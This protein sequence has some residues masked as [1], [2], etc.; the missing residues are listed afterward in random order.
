MLKKLVNDKIESMKTYFNEKLDSLKLDLQ[1]TTVNHPVVKNVNSTPMFNPDRH[2]NV[3][4]FGCKEEE[5]TDSKRRFDLI[6]R[7]VTSNLR[8]IGIDA[9]PSIRDFF[10]RGKQTPGKNRPIILRASN[11]WEKRKILASYRSQKA[12][13]NLGFTVL[14]D[15]P[16]NPALKE[17]KVKARKL[18]ED[19]KKEAENK[20]TMVTKSFSARENG[21]ITFHLRNGKWQQE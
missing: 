8:E 20:Q 14:E 17:L 13:K 3:V 6:S 11:I 15:H 18:N 10:R 9:E 7:T 4:M 16:L 5:E 1:P 12:Q 19:L 21:L 2:L